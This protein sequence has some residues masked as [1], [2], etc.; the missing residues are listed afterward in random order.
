MKKLFKL[1]AFFTFLMFFAWPVLAI[2]QRVSIDIDSFGDDKIYIIWAAENIIQTR[3]NDIYVKVKYENGELVADAPSGMNLNALL[4]PQKIRAE[5]DAEKLRG[6]VAKI[7]EKAAKDKKK[8]DVKTSLK[9]TDQQFQDL[10]D[11][12][13]DEIGG[14]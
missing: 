11:V 12:L 8:N 6:E 1:S 2:E 7:A 5:I 3:N 9:L 14:I 10:V 13:T 4:T